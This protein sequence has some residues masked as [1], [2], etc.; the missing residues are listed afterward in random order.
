MPNATASICTSYQAELADELKATLGHTGGSGSN[1]CS[2]Y[3]W[4]KVMSPKTYRL[5]GQ[6]KLFFLNKFRAIILSFSSGHCPAQN[7][8]AFILE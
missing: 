6:K 1:H 5:N 3:V 2:C 7:A 4:A 8:I